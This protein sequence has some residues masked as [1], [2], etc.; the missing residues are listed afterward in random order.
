MFSHIWF[1]S[2]LSQTGTVSRKTIDLLAEHEVD[3]ML[4]R[5]LADNGLQELGVEAAEERSNILSVAKIL[6]P[7]I[8]SN[9]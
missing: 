2:K 9:Q 7:N 3:L 6:E 4:I 1:L 8:A 5:K